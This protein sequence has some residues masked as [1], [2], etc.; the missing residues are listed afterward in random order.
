[1]FA[2]AI[3]KH[4]SQA[5]ICGDAECVRRSAGIPLLTVKIDRFLVWEAPL[6]HLNFYVKG[7]SSYSESG[8]V[9]GNY[10]F[11]RS[12][13]GER[14]GSLLSTHSKFIDEMNKL[15]NAFAEGL[16]A[17]IIERGLAKPAQ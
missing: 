9:A 11:E 15:S 1:M 4:F 2:S 3:R 16:T 7:N 12:M 5:L 13:L 17:E 14:L 6:N 8:G 10:E